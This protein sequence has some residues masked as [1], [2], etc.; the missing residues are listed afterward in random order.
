MNSTRYRLFLFNLIS[1]RRRLLDDD[2]YH[3]LCKMCNSQTDYTSSKSEK[4]L[5]EKLR[6]ERQFVTEEDRATIEL[7][8]K[9]MGHFS[10]N[11]WESN[12]L[13][14]TVEI[15]QNCNMKCSYCYIKTRTKSDAIMDKKYIDAIH[16]F[17]TRF[18]SKLSSI[19]NTSIINITGGET[20]INNESVDIINYIAKIWH[21]SK[22]VIFTNGINI[23]KYYDNLPLNSI[24]EVRVSLDGV[25]KIYIEGEYFINDDECQNFDKIIAGIKKLLDNGVSVRIVTVLSKYNYKEYSNLISLLEREK[26]SQMPNYIHEYDVVHDFTND[27]DMDES[28]NNVKDVFEIQEYLLQSHYGNKILFPSLSVL[29]RALSRPVGKL[30][31][32]KH[33]RCSQQF[34]TNYYFSCDGNIYFCGFAKEGKGIIGKYYPQVAVDNLAITTLANRSVTNNKRCWAC[35]YKFICLGGC[36]LTAAGGGLEMHCGVFAVDDVIDNLEFDY[37]SL[38]NNR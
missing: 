25:K 16:S 23:L 9:E 21:R 30:E 18:S 14:F 38:L 4:E 26:I 15:T 11:N 32:P 6:E 27:L 20:L 8:L 29:Y 10:F 35:P 36:P 33:Q 2:E 13:R 3:V 19:N 7:K 34:L 31:L 12:D 37:E 22:L 5:I 17:Y 1:G 24:K 28:F